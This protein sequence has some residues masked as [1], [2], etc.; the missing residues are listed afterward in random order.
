VGSD[1]ASDKLVGNEVELTIDL[2]AVEE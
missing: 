1:E 2:E